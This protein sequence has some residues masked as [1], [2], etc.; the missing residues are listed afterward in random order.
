[1][2]RWIGFTAPKMLNG[3]TNSH[4][5]A[6]LNAMGNAVSPRGDMPKHRVPLNRRTQHV[7]THQYL[8]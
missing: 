5:G 6:L 7:V 2:H 1:M 3:L 4:R 8:Q